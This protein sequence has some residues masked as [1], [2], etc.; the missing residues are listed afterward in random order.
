[1]ERLAVAQAAYK[2]LGRIVSAKD[3]GSLRSRMSGALLE[4]FGRDGTDRRRVMLNGVKVGML[5][6]RVP[7]P[8]ERTVAEVT[9]EAQLLDWGADDMRDYLRSRGLVEDFALWEREQGYGPASIPGVTYK[10]IAERGQA[11]TILNGC[12]PEDVAAALGEGLPEAISG[13]LAEGG[14]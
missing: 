2:A 6:V 1:M 11:T 12:R 14:E 5:S 3:P 4:D 8:R 7:E 9:D 10:T 13:L